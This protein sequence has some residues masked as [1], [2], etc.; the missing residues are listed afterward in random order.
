[1]PRAARVRERQDART[2]CP[3]QLSEQRLVLDSL[4]GPVEKAFYISETN[5]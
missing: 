3:R 4:L 1:M 2:G 5:P